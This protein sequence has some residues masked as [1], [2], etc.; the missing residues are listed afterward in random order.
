MSRLIRNLGSLTLLA[1][2]LVFATATT[3]ESTEQDVRSSA[4]AFSISAAELFADYEANE[5]AA[6]QRYKDKVFTVTGTVEDIGEDITGTPY[7]TLKAS[8]LFSVQ[9]MFSNSYR[10]QL[11]RVS[12]GSS[13]SLTC[14]GKGK[15]GNVLLGGCVFAR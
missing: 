3:E 6:D 9:C 4:P 2:F 10:S 14:K 5:L 8:P 11:A 12:K 15:M 7:L 1:V 13:V